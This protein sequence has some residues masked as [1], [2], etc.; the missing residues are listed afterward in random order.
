MQPEPAS[1]PEAPPTR[2]LIPLFVT[3]GATSLIYETLWSRELHLVFGTS[4]LAISTTLAAFMAGLTA[5]GLI[6]ARAVGRVRRPLA[7]YAALELFIGLYALIFPA[8]AR[9]TEPLYTAFHHA[10]SP[11]P[12][13]FG[14][15]QFLLMGLLLLPPTLCMGA[16][17]PLLA[18][19]AVMRGGE[20]GTSVGRLYGANTIGAVLG[21][22]LAGFALLPSLGLSLTT[23]LAATANGLLALVAYAMGRG[24]PDLPRDEAPARRE[25][26]AREAPLWAL[27]A[28]AGFASLLCEVAWFRVMVLT[29]GGSA[30]AF[31]TMLL[32][33]LV[34]IGLGGWLGGAWADRAHAA[35]GRPAVLGWLGV[36][37]AYIGL[38]SWGAMY[39][40]GELPYAY[41]VVYDL[42]AESPELLWPAMVLFSLA[43]LLPPTLGMGAAFPFLVRAS[44]EPGQSEI[45][46]PV[47]RLYGA[48]TF[49]AILGAAGGGFVLLP[50]LHVRGSV[51]LAIGVYLVAGALVWAVSARRLGRP[52]WQPALAVTAAAA[53]LVVGRIAPP[54]WDPMLM[55]AGMY[56]YV[57]EFSD[58][59]W[60]GLYEFAV[61]PYEL[62]YYDEGLSSVVTVARSKETGNIWLANN[63]KVD[64]STSIDMPT[65]VLVSDLGFAFAPEAE[66]VLVI[67]LASG[68][69]A[70]SVTRHPGPTQ[71][72]LVELEPAIVTASAFFEPLNGE[73]LKD[74][75]VTMFTN[76][77]RNHVVLTPPGTY[78]LVISEPSNPWLSGVSNLFTHEFF[79]LGK[80]RLK[81]GGVWAQWVQMYGM[82]YEDLLSLLRTFCESFP[83]VRMFSTI[84]DAD[85]VLVG[86]EAPLDLDPA[87]FEAMIHES[88][89]VAQNLAGVGVT[90]ASD[91]LSFHQL[92]RDAL[93]DRSGH[94]EINTDDNMRVEYG[95]PR[96]LHEDTAESNFRKLLYVKEQPPALPLEATPTVA[97]KVA[98]AQAYARRED[99]LRAL[100]ALKAAEAQRS[101][102]ATPDEL[103]EPIDEQIV[104][105][106]TEYQRR[107]ERH[108]AG[109]DAED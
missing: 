95:A 45:G 99:W 30:Y 101:A 12:L 85:L 23:A 49:G 3:S 70:G 40:Y 59:S 29:L 19:F 65:Q 97:D 28:S 61:E 107:L 63:G 83:H 64:A 17:L 52:S 75:R 51:L 108:L 91:I 68:I 58:H 34:G 2:L 47:G 76:D 56:K 84:Q 37:F 106:F 71:I 98:L 25:I 38:I 39:T 42:V 27:A 89:A 77:G 8:L 26:S 74:P 96:H 10:A 7:V 57:S 79:E 32:G 14:A 80:R 93:L 13:V 86:S 53:A 90:G 1:R 109:E 48:N 72:D 88:P 21:T 36:I 100:L 103:A 62:L 78:D 55:T 87:R 102:E 105:L 41:V 66:R 104:A 54:P 31:S 43:V 94:I 20:A 9:A 50:W 5:G 11:T 73:P 46:G 6:A 16:T 69:T 24:Q 92:D 60:E 15:V 33:F 18:R 35:G 81:P 67:G 82:G 4:Q 22:G 44:V